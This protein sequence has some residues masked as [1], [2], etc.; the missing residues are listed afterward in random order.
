M[1]P[2]PAGLGVALV[3]PF[4]SDANVDF[5]ALS[6]L[7]EHVVC[8]GVDYVVALGTTAETPAL[9]INERIAVLNAVKRCVRKRVPVV[10]GI[11]GNNTAAVIKS[12]HDFDLDGVDAILSVTPFYNKPSQRGLYEH[13]MAVAKNSPVP[14]ILYNIPSR[15]GI[16]MDPET[17]LK[18][19]H[20]ADNIIGIKEAC[21]K[22]DQIK[23]IVDNRPDDFFVI[24]G[25]DSLACDI[26]ALGGDGLISVAANAFP[27]VMERMIS[28]CRNGHFNNA[29]ECGLRLKPMIDCL[30]A[31]CNPTGIKAALALK[32]IIRNN[33][34]LPLVAATEQ[35]SMNIGSLMSTLGL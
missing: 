6:A 3:T 17:T 5:D 14:V 28:D 27:N 23:F 33:L 22:I 7:V 15:T 19:A 31:E 24:S 20:D 10:A 16:N 4:D 9:F 13:F 18:L 29:A 35:L 34:R 26:M 12:L 30:F 32:G 2:F 11:G 1:R 8:G 21:G 25:D